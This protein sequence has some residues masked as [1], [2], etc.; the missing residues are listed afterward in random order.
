[1]P[2]TK[3]PAGTKILTV[4]DCTATTDSITI[5]FS[6]PVVTTPATNP[7]GALV[8]KNYS[9][10]DPGSVD[11]QQIMTI[12][13]AKRRNKGF[14]ATHSIDA[15]GS[16]VTWTFTSS[17]PQRDEFQPGDSITVIIQKVQ[18]MAKEEID[19][20]CIVTGAVVPGESGVSKNVEDATAYPILTEEVGYSP[21]PISRPT[22]GGGFSTGGAS[23]LGL[24]QV[25]SQAVADVLGWKP[26]SGDPKG[27]VGALTQ[28]FSLTD[29]EGHVESTWNPRT[30]TVQTDLAG[31]I[32]G[33]QASLYTRAKVALDASLPLLDGLYALNPAA[34]TEY[35]NALRDMAK[36]QFSEIVK[37]F[38]VVPPSI[39]R[40]NTYFKILLGAKNL[41]FSTEPRVECDPD[42]V[43]GTLGDLRDFYGI[44]FLKNEKKNPYSN[45]VDDEENITNFRVISDYATSLLQSWLS[46]GRYFKLAVK[47]RK[48]NPDAFLG[49]QLVLISRQLNV[50][51]ESVNEVRFVLDSV[52]IGPN[53][54][55]TLLLEFNPST[56]LPSMYLEDVLIEID[57][58]V[59]DELPRLLKGGGRIAVSNNLAPLVETL[60]ELVSGARNPQNTGD[61]PKG[62]NTA[63]VKHA[64]SDLLDQLKQLKTQCD[65][66]GMSV[67]RTQDSLV[68]VP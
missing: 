2:A 27:F 6:S 31:G 28:S 35:E 67:P 26:N 20:L 58:S 24:G 46:N 36:S 53:E 39:L 7:H 29:I 66:I 56:D 30:Y 45:S 25:A 10:S 21:S 64:L 22:G 11:F 51:A 50:I 60:I 44:Y 18:G 8:F 16:A 62:F 19:G 42:K 15:T 40:V 49:T 12:T 13:D 54:R 5:K 68:A 23:S 14:S 34:D 17:D 59:S 32:T 61:L 9:I 4:T 63:R 65:Q 57:N 33:A 47:D 37:Q 48:N 1:M 41:T 52:F 43:Q 55:Q 38:G 3:V